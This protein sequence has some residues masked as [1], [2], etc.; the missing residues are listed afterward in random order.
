MPGLL[1]AANTSRHCM[2]NNCRNIQLTQ[3]PIS[4][5]V[6]LLSYFNIYIPESARICESHLQNM[7]VEQLSQNM[8][9]EQLEFTAAHVLDIIQ[10]YTKALE[11]KTIL[12]MQNLNDVS[13]K[14]L[15][16]WTGL[17]HEQFHQLLDQTPSLRRESRSPNLDLGVY[18]C[19]IR[20]GE[21]STRIGTT[22]GISESSVN[23]KVHQVR[24]HLLTDFVPMH[25][26]L[27]HITREEVINRNRIIPNYIFG[28]EDSPHALLICDGTYIYIEKSSNFFYQRCTYSL[29]KYRNLIKPFL[30]VCAD[31]HIVDITGPYAATT[32]DADIL[33]LVME[34][35]GEPIEDGAFHYLFEEND[36][37][38]LDRG[39]RDA[40]PITEEYG[41][42]AF[43]PPTRRRGET[44]LTTEEANKSRT[45]TICRWVIE[46]INGRFK[47]DFKI[48]R[49]RSFNRASRNT[50]N[51]F[52]IAGALINCFQ[53]PYADSQ[54]TNEFIEAIR[55]NLHKPNL[56]ADYVIQRNLNRQR[57]TFERMEA[58]NQH[59]T[60]FP[61][62]SYEEL[63]LISVG[64]YHVKLARSYC[65]EH[66]KRTGVYEIEYYRQTEQIRFSNE[67]NT[68]TL[69]R[70]KIQSRHVRNKTYYTYILYDS[71]V[72]GR[73]AIKEYYCSCIHGRRTLGSCAHVISILYYL[74]WARHNMA[75]ME[76]PAAFLDDVILD[77]EL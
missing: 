45:I 34:N 21:P 26:G 23:R 57:V 17:N 28:N 75:E 14:D 2:I 64:T 58:D 47:R 67:Q 5:K 69:I 12:N 22:F 36:V 43:M 35:H 3:M 29:H 9:N 25:I 4:I 20:S 38:I 30:I 52:K 62:L 72:Q 16:F 55:V 60:D 50:F 44:Q 70:C 66:V 6:Y 51:D 77:I 65:S 39:F 37:L 10:T 61:Q 53:E 48:F 1:R 32:S 46:A 31:G 42:N 11:Q 56:L 19:K 49:H 41:Y 7:S 8:W 27:D 13:P 18:L 63:I 24:R 40:I 15:R 54:Y 68:Q 73:S 74:G 76:H 59:L 71:N 33:A